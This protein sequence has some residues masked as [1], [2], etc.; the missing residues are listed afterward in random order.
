MV[1][2]QYFCNYMV[3]GGQN[4]TII[5]HGYVKSGLNPLSLYDIL[6]LFPSYSFYLFYVNLRF[7]VSYSGEIW[8]G[9]HS[10]L[11]WKKFKKRRMRFIFDG[12]SI[13]FYKTLMITPFATYRSAVGCNHTEN[14]DELKSGSTLS[15][16][17]W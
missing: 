14:K 1:H 12:F 15:D 16:L 13:R 8:Y 9:D 10:Y 5:G 11:L 7:S 17:L 2:Q 4:P 6:F 3:W